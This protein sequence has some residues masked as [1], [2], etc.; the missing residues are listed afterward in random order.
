MLAEKKGNRP[1]EAFVLAAMSKGSLSKALDM[2]R[3]D[4][5]SRRNWLIKA[6][7]LDQ[8]KP[9]RVKPTGLLFSISAQLSE[10]KDTLEDC[11]E[12]IKSWLRDLIIFKYQ[13]EKIIH[14]DCA[15]K[16]KNLSN[17]FTTNSLLHKIEAVQLTQLTIQRSNTNMKLALDLLMLKLIEMA[18]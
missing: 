6:V 16:I 17:E 15:D 11:L 8:C 7:G 12:I 2:S 18:N 1:E 10:N 4:W 13:P 5:I 3:I 14:R 9:I